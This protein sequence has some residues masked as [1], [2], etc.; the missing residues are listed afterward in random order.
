M[1]RVIALIAILGML[2]LSL[3]ACDKQTLATGAGAAVGGTLGGL[4]GDTPGAVVG[5]VA[6][7]VVG[8]Q[9]AKPDK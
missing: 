6:G 3:T 8:H 9:L 7:A 2:A 5:G 1:K 4:V